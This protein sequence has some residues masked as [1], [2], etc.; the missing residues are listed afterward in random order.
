MELPFDAWYKRAQFL[1][2]SK[3]DQTKQEHWYFRL[4]GLEDSKNNYLYDELPI[5]KTDH[6]T[7]FMIDPSDARGINCRLG[8]KG[9]IAE[10]HF[11]PSR[12][13]IV[14]MG[15]QRR[16]II[17]HPRQCPNLEL[18]PRYHPSGR[19]S[20]VNW[21]TASRETLQNTSFVAA[22]AMTENGGRPFLQAMGSEVLMQAGDALYLPD[23]WMHFIV[24][25]GISYQCNARSGQTTHYRREIHNCG[26]PIGDVE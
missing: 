24:S 2:T 21:S 18:Y 19:H 11:D 9:V 3:K 22:D 12:N 26:F 13:W 23:S 25:L 15:G 14:V 17:S 5:F 1:Q 20:R 7:F 4:N 16:Y 10:C 8:M 6:S